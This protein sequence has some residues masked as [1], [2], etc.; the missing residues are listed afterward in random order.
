MHRTILGA[1]VVAALLAA[2][3]A[4][5]QDFVGVAK[6][7]KLVTFSAD[8]TRDAEAV[9]VK[10]IPRE[11]TIVG[12]D[13]RPSNGL[14]YALTDAGLL[15]TVDLEAGRA[16][17][18]MGDLDTNPIAPI[19][20]EGD[21]FGFD[22]NPAADGNRG[23]LRIVSDTTQNLRQRFVAGTA[24]TFTPGSPLVVDG[25]LSSA[26][27]VAAA[28]T[29]PDT[30]PATG[31]T[32]YDLDSDS[33]QLVIQN[34]P[35]AGTLV[36]GPTVGFD[37]GPATGFDIASGATTGY[38]TGEGDHG[39]QVLYAIDLATGATTELG[40]IGGPKGIRGLAAIG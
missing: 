13:V 30:D 2:P 5:A 32:L 35:N 20:L 34:P 17:R 28:Y 16:T 29:N 19:A 15:Y 40:T 37:V 26:G 22:F 3:A 11:D 6:N 12:I 8:D 1:A 25:D 38:A 7:D 31:T 27:V 23:A 10:G 4:Q 36:S 14:L 39:R 33:D 21:A 9:N 24:P 18:A